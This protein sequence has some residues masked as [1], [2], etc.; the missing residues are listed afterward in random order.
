ML[1]KVRINE[2]KVR[3]EVI[4]G[5]QRITTIQLFYDKKLEL[6][7]TLKSMT[8]GELLAGRRYD[9]LNVEQKQW[10]DKL[11]LEA[12]IIHSIEDKPNAHV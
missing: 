12:N 3:Y 10:F 7:K 1:R 5:Q 11:N 2:E 8:R 9:Q 6:P 4:D